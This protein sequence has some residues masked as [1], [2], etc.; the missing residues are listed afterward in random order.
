MSYGKSFG[1]SLSSGFV[2]PVSASAGSAGSAAAGGAGHGLASSLAS[3]ASAALP[4]V[5][6]AAVAAGAVFLTRAALRGLVQAADTQ[7]GQH[8]QT[9]QDRTEAVA[10]EKSFAQ[11][12]ARN[13][14]IERL[15]GTIGALSGD[16]SDVPK[17]FVYAGQDIH[18]LGRW[19]DATDQALLLAE[20]ELSRLRVKAALA[21]PDVRS[22]EAAARRR[23]RA[24]V[25]SGITRLEHYLFDEDEKAFHR[26]VVPG[27]G[28]SSRRSDVVPKTVAIVL[29]RLDGA[30]SPDDQVRCLT[31]AD[32]V[33]S[34]KN[35]EDQ[36]LELHIFQRMA[37][38]AI[39]EQAR[40]AA[41]AAEAAQ[42]LI[43][44]AVLDQSS[45]S[46][47][48]RRVL[49]GL[50]AVAAEQ[51]EMSPVLRSSAH[52]LAERAVRTAQDACVLAN[53]RQVFD[54]LAY[55]VSSADGTTIVLKQ[56]KQAGQATLTVDRGR[57]EAA[58]RADPQARGR[59]DLQR[60]A[61][62][63]TVEK[64]IG[65]LGD[66]ALTVDGIVFDGVAVPRSQP[67]EQAARPR[68]RDRDEEQEQQRN[69]EPGS[70]E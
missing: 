70:E 36:F 31:Q 12:M 64:A 65:V 3:G 32:I 5:A 38:A 55:D 58:F 45:A 22:D 24:V 66:Q 61:W 57:V 17:A 4:F 6:G 7:K 1:I 63:E 21:H 35:T 10:W 25:S 2:P 11:V 18:A 26:E 52:G 68:R 33:L 54:S 30:V 15:R 34:T 27:V 49:Q 69:N 47:H 28:P 20:G 51:E 44:L 9:I 67:G 39:A 16:H 40:R 56:S 60:D 48:V 41:D 42:L 50:R 59:V 8:E 53:L 14:R 46:A 43:G 37:D 62:R 19:C 13:I 23:S 29:Q